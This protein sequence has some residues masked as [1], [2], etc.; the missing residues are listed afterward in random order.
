MSTIVATNIQDR[1]SSISVPI[2]A[3]INQRTNYGLVPSN[4]SGDATNDIDFTAGKCWDTTGTNYITVA[5]MTKRA[6][7]TW[8]AGTNQGMIDTGAFAANS[9][10]Y[11]WA[12]LHTDGTTD[13]LMSLADTWAGVTKPTGYTTGQ[14]I[15]AIAAKAVSAA[16]SLVSVTEAEVILTESPGVHVSSALT[17]DVAATATLNQVPALSLGSFITNAQC[18]TL[19]TTL[20]GFVGD[21]SRSG[22]TFVASSYFYGATSAIRGILGTASAMTNASQQVAVGMTFTAGTQTLTLY[23]TGYTFMRRFNGT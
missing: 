13:I 12:I 20:A 1:V 7:A 19:V 6:D 15:H 23:A 11:F 17:T 4:N 9:C 21:I 2:V 5:A 22:T 18:S 16:W 3:V 10:Y 14:L 8:A